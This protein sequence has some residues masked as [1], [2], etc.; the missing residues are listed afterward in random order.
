[1][2]RKYASVYRVRLIE[3][4]LIEPAGHGYI[5]FAVPYLRDYLREHAAAGV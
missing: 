3:A 5:D 4:E 1:V 2:D